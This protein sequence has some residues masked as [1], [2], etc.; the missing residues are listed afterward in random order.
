M[1]AGAQVNTARPTHIP[2]NFGLNER[3]QAA[4]RCPAL[5]DGH[6]D[7][8]DAIPPLS[9]S[10]ARDLCRLLWAQGF[11]IEYLEHRFGVKRVAA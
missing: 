4:L 5:D 1:L 2:I 3:R 7:P 8:I 10:A 11:S 6:R 9:E